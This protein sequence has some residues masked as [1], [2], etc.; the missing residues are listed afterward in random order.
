EPE[1]PPTRPRAPRTT[2]TTP[3]PLLTRPHSVRDA[4]L[5]RCG[6]GLLN[7]GCPDHRYCSVKDSPAGG[8]VTN[9]FDVPV[10]ENV[11]P[12]SV[13]RMTALNGRPDTV[14]RMFGGPDGSHDAVVGETT[15][16]GRVRVPVAVN[17]CG[18]P[19]A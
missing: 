3:H 5:A 11:C 4:D 2:T 13:T 12:V 16:E 1:Y 19:A 9:S 6:E 14:V 7:A 17:A 10:S 15:V 18:G 8:P